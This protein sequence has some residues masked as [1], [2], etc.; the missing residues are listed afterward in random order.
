MNWEAARSIDVERIGRLRTICQ[1]FPEAEEALIQGRPLFHVRRRRFAILNGTSFPIRK[2]WMGC[3]SS[4]HFATDKQTYAALSRDPR[5]EPS[6]H[7][8]F[9]GWLSIP[10]SDDADWLEIDHLIESAY[11][12]VA[13]NE[14]VLELDRLEGLD[15]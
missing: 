2:R 10:L 1:R 9:R 12:H 15:A 6:P 7:H 13:T 11:R 5:F 4:L 3:G 8:G 14:L